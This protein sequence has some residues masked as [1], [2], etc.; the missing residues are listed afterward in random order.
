MSPRRTFQSCGI[1]SSCDTFS[2][3]PSLV[4]SASVA[5]DE[6]LAE[7]LADALLGAG[8]HRAELEHLEEAAAPADALAAVE[9]RPPARREL[10]HRDHERDRQREQI[11]NSVA[12]MMSSARSSRSMRRC[13]ASGREPDVAADERLFERWRRRLPSRSMVD[14]SRDERSHG[15]DHVQV[16][17][18]AG[19]EAEARAFYGGLLGLEEIPKPAGA[20]GPRRLLVP[21]RR[22][23]ASRRRRGAVRARPQGAPGPRRRRPRRARR[24]AAR[25]RARGRVRRRDPRRERFHVADPF[26]NRLEF[27]QACTQL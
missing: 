21:G 8:P 15:I 25:G 4:S 13:S 12:S 6:L 2:Q 5:C 7:V 1:S 19:C 27:R 26:G 14:R 10:D 20:R 11:P 22:A 18:P 17:A 9:D 23:G 16:A 3:R 24:A